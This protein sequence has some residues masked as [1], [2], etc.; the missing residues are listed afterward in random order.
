MLFSLI[1][2]GTPNEK[3]DTLDNILRIWYPS[4][5]EESLGDSLPFLEFV[6]CLD[7]TTPDDQRQTNIYIPLQKMR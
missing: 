4:L 3:E 2:E 5:Q 6:H 7:K 1:M